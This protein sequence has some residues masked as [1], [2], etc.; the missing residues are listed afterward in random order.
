MM[1]NPKYLNEPF[2][3]NMAWVDL[4]GIAAFTKT[5]TIIRG[6]RVPILRGQIGYGVDFLSQRWKWSRGKVERFLNNL[7]IEKEIVRQKT[8]VTTIISICNY[9]L[10][11][12]NGNTDCNTDNKANSKPKS[13]K[14]LVSEGIKPPKKVKEPKE[15]KEEEVYTPAQTESFNKFQTW[16]KDKA[17]RLLELRDSFTIDQFLKIRSEFDNKT[18]IDV[19]LSMQ[20]YKDLLK[21]YVSAD[22]T[23][24]NW[25]KLRQ[26]RQP[27]PPPKLPEEDPNAKTKERMSNMVHNIK[28]QNHEAY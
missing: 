7:E 13:R 4:V 19:I 8:N 18:I 1:L 27:E 10:Y 25:V 26:E 28:Q 5:Y 22:L 2:C 3:K 11:Q 23:F 16:L 17:P 24:R 9:N 15:V 14:P 21:K 12:G 20:N 6:I